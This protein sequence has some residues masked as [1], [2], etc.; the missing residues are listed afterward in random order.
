MEG[1]RTLLCC[2]FLGS[3]NQL[4]MKSEMGTETFNFV[5]VAHFQFYKWNQIRLI[6]CISIWSGTVSVLDRSIIFIY[7]QFQSIECILK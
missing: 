3:A 2:T 6:H 5:R 4:R 1:Q 7:M